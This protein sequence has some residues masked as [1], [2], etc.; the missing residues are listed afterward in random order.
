MDFEALLLSLDIHSIFADPM[1][2]ES[3]PKCQ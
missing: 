3:L 2:F 1:A